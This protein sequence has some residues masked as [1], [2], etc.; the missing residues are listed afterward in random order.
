MRNIKFFLVA[1]LLCTMQTILAQTDSVQTEIM[2]LTE[3]SGGINWSNIGTTILQTLI[4][5]LIIGAILAMIGHMIYDIFFALKKYVPLNAETE[6][7]IRKDMGLKPMTEED[8]NELGSKLSDIMDQWTPVASSEDGHE[9]FILTKYSQVKKTRKV[10]EEVA[11]AHPDSAKLVEYYNDILESFKNAQKRQF[12]GSK[13]Y[14]VLSLLFSIFMGYAV[15]WTTPV[16]YVL[17]CFIGVYILST[18]TP[19]YLINKKILKGSTGPKFMTGLL[20]GVFGIAGSA[21]TYTTITKWGDGTITK[22]DDYSEHWIALA[23]TII[24]LMLLCS[25]MVIIAFINYLRNYVF[26]I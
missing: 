6:A 15:G 3:S 26:H 20:A 1:I 5:V 2:E 18:M 16:F 10:L 19:T 9:Q 24:L 21:A 22:E 12:H 4:Y 11:A 8:L 14:I 25:C 13:T 23:F 7:E 17:L